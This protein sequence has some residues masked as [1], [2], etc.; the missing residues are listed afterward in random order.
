[1][2]DVEK[3]VDGLFADKVGHERVLEAE[4]VPLLQD[5]WD[6]VAGLGLP[7]IG[8]AESD[9]GSGGSIADVV[10]LM[11]AV[12]KH[13]VPLPLLEHHL[14]TW[15]VGRCDGA[16]PWT[17]APP[18]RTLAIDGE[19]VT[20]TLRDVAWGSAAQRVVA[21][22]DGT[23]VVLDPTDAAVTTGR[24]IA[25]QPRDELAFNNAPAE[26]LTTTAD[27]AQRGAVLRAAQMAGAMQAVYDLT[28]QYVYQRE[29]F[30]R[31]VGTFQAV[32]RHLV[33]LAQMATMTQLSVDRAA[34]A[35]ESDVDSSFA[36]YA[37]K[38][39]ANANAAVSI[40]SGHQAH[41]AIGVT[42]EYALQDFT[43]RLN[44]WRADWGTEIDLADR[45]G[46]AALSARAVARIATDEGA[47]TV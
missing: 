18:Q 23:V 9:G 46:G 31:P 20:G 40:K 34:A 24:D 33:F 45:I 36:A 44:A 15:L 38:L 30:G 3:M 42:R 11:T 43:R 12:G 25:G 29:Q 37:T 26:V 10:T 5:L 22:V 1:M 35:L 7:G 2:S 4:R 47:I 14:A 16:G 21:Q 39:L 17:V 13:A 41:G 8:V 27:L 6:T 32:R 28:N 19:R